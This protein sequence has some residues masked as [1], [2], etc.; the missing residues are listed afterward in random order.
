V[1]STAS[2]ESNPRFE[3]L[4]YTWGDKKNQKHIVL[5]GDTF[6]I[7]ENIEAALRRLRYTNKLRILWVDAICVNQRDDIEKNEQVLLMRQIYE[8]AER[9]CIWLGEPTDASHLGVK[10]IQ[11]NGWSLSMG[12]YQW[13]LERN[14]GKLTLPARESFTSSVA[15]QTGRTW[16]KNKTLVK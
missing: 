9:V 5:N 12:W 1:L 2:L 11:S 8:S 3:A 16:W 7:R 13:K 10:C 15:L 6:L 4:S 14:F